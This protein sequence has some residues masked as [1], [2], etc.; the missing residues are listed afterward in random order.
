MV[1]IKREDDDENKSQSKGKEERAIEKLAFHESMLSAYAMT[2][3][4]KVQLK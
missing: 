1:K 2:E 4:T 3:E